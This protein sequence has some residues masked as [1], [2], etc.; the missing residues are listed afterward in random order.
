VE[1]K[2]WSADPRIAEAVRSLAE[3]V[4]LIPLRGAPHVSLIE[5]HL[6]HGLLE[7]ARSQMPL[8]NIG[9]ENAFLVALGS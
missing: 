2:H 8:S 4:K 5:G 3:A 1:L 9:Q 7:G 6:A